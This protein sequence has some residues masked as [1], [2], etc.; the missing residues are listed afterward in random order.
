[1]CTLIVLHRCVPGAPLVVAANRDEHLDRP[2]EPP[3]IRSS[4]F[5]AVLAPL[6]VRAG[7]TWLGLN[8]HGVFAALTNRRCSEPDPERRSRGLLVTDLLAAPSAAE[9][10]RLIAELP[11][12]AYNPFNLFV[13]DG[14]E[15]FLASYVDTPVV[16]EVL[17]GAHV[18]GNVDPADLGDSKVARVRERA[19]KAASVSRAR[20]IDELADVCREHDSGAGPLGDTC[21]H[22]DG[23]GTRSSALLMLADTEDESRLFFADGPPCRTEYINSTS[24][25]RALSRQASDA[26]GESSSRTM[27]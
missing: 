6:D 17:P 3:A 2:A 5:G 7:G 12:Q 26:S 14:S 25:L 18:V 1:M 21:V 27:L 13:S 10:A 19:E 8:P 20:V 11:E 22:F 24:L 15:A 23:Y 4:G 9:A 16:S